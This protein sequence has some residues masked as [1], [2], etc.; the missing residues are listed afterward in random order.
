MERGRIYMDASE[1]PQIDAA[2]PNYVYTSN[3][4]SDITNYHDRLAFATTYLSSPQS[5]CGIIF[6]CTDEDMKT[7]VAMLEDCETSWNHP[8]LLPYIFVELQTRRLNTLADTQIDL[9]EKTGFEFET[10]RNRG[11]DE[12]IYEVSQEFLDVRDGSSIVEAGLKA[13]IGQLSKLI[14]HSEALLLAP[15]R[16]PEQTE[17]QAE[18]K[19]KEE[20]KQRAEDLI[21][22]SD[23][24]IRDTERFI[25]RFKQI[26]LEYEELIDNCQINVKSTTSILDAYANQ[27]A[28]RSTVKATVLTFIAMIYLPATTMATILA[29]PIFKFEADWRDIFGHPAPAGNDDNSNGSSSATSSASLASSSD[30][31]VPVV[32]FYLWV[33][34]AMSVGLTW[35]TVEAWWL[36]THIHHNL[37]WHRSPTIRAISYCIKFPWEIV[38]SCWTLLAGTLSEALTWTLG[39][40]GRTPD[41]ATNTN[42]QASDQEKGQASRTSTSA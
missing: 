13:A 30:S 32:S 11:D 36:T 18:K 24:F 6:G 3:F 37:V 8:L 9:S 40:F 7:V 17:E 12:R 38:L 20:A 29:I 22:S 23:A 34:I 41:S 39:I 5:S 1:L 15:K 10:L 25:S 27:V 19:A 26:I 2:T 35:L 21:A 33:Y 4:S 14:A 16:A 28:R 31:T 42:S